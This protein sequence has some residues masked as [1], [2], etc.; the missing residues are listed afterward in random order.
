MLKKFITA[1]CLYLCVSLPVFADRPSAESL[2][3]LF[4]VT[5]A[6]TL[7]DSLSASID[8]TMRQGME[9]ALAGQKLTDAQ[10]RMVDS[11]ALKSAQI[12]RDEV[13]WTKLKPLY[14]RI[15]QESLTQEDIDGLVA[16]YRSPAGDAMVRKMPQVMQRTMAEVQA[17]LGP[18][19][20]RLKVAQ[21][22]AIAE[23]K[24]LK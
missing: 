6:S 10:R 23:A 4:E 13:T 18:M 19:M 1:V 11:M 9:Q 2:D 22:E 16:F 21:A 3:A 5:R 20:E 12:V 24:S 8:Q 17:I 15:Y 7:M 14:V